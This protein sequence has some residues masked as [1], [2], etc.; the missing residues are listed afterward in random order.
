ML[1]SAPGTD[2]LNMW[3]G[4][5]D[6]GSTLE[7]IANHIASSDAFQNAYPAF[8]TN[9]EFATA[10]LNSSL[11]AEV[12]AEI[13]AAAAVVV[14]G[15]LN[16]GTS[17]GELALLVVGVLF[18]I[19][20]QG[21]AHGLAADFGAAA[22]A[23]ANKVDVAEYYTL[24]Q[25]IS[26]PSSSAI[27]DVSS[28]ADSVT[29]AKTAIDNL[30]AAGQTGEIFL[31]TSAR[32][33]LV[34]TAGGD[35]FFA[36]PSDDGH[37]L[38]AYDSIGAGEGDDTLTVYG[39]R[40]D[41]IINTER[42]SNLE[43]LVVDTL[44]GINVDTSDWT[45]L[46]SIELARFS[47]DV[48]VVA[49]GA[50]VSVGKTASG[51]TSI[52]GA[53]GDLELTA[54]K[55]AVVTIGAAGE[56]TSVSVKGGASVDISKTGDGGQ[57]ETVTSVSLDGVQR[58]LGLDGKRGTAMTPER[59]PIYDADANNNDIADGLE[60]N[61]TI[62]E[63][64]LP[65]ATPDVV[66][67]ARVTTDDAKMAAM[68]TVYYDAEGNVVAS[69]AEGA[70][71]GKDGPSA[72]VL[73]K[74]IESISLSNSDAIVAVIN[75]SDDPEDI[76]V[77]VDKFGK[78]AKGA[79]TAKL[80]LAGDGAAENVSI[81]VAGDSDFYLG[82]DA[83]KTVS[84]SGDA[85]V[86]LKV[87]MFDTAVASGTLESVTITDG[88]SV[89]MDAAGM[90]K[91]ESI[92]A[93]AGTGNNKLTGIGA[94]VDSV[95]GGSGND[96][97]ALAAHNIGGTMVSLGAGDDTFSSGEANNKSRVD[98]GEGMDTLN[99]KSD[100]GFT[101]TPE[102]GKANS[103]T[104]YSGFEALDVGGS[105]EATYNISL[106]GVSSVRVGGV[107]TVGTVTLNNMGD[108]MGISVHG[109]G[110]GTTATIVHN[111][112]EREVG[113]VRYSGELD[114]SLA[115]NGG[116]KDT[117]ATTNGEAR[118][119]LTTNGEIEVLNI[120]SSASAGGAGSAAKDRPSAGHYE[121][122]LTLDGANAV[123]AIAVSGNAKLMVVAANAGFGA[124]ELVDAED[125]TAGVTVDASTATQAVEMHGGSGGD[126]FTGTGQDDSLRGNGGKD[127][128]NGGGGDDKLRGGAG[129]DTLDGGGNTNVFEYTSTSDSQLSYSATGA[130][131]GFDTIEN[132]AGG[133]NT[134]SLGRALF[135][136]FQGGIKAVDSINNTDADDPPGTPNGT[137]TANSLRA[138]IG[139][140]D[141]L[142][143]TTGTP[144]EN[145]FGGGATI[146]NS[147]AVVTS[148]VRSDTDDNDVI[149]NSDDANEMTWVFI[150]VDGDGDFDAAVDMVI[151]LEGTVTIELGDFTM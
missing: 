85:K 27:A 21:D 75:G 57:S 45:G 146:K 136:S 124:L 89:T 29:A 43:N 96:T 20:A 98:G 80:C 143:E 24:D 6:D 93:S 34:G 92:D 105:A 79:V 65:D 148:N 49:D 107:S 108:G 35:S 40:D 71:T 51:V 59:N 74:A 11:G 66:D 117:K 25:R 87:T 113:D 9:E 78:H 83:T 116:A 123:E 28:D 70:A 134:I 7:E 16:D 90:G 10:F 38:Q 133:T 12:S 22:S 67:D 58:N 150:D 41:L 114:V 69:D 60:E 50:S 129:A 63:F 97:V 61:A 106:L 56:T 99:L 18:D 72:H 140:G 76:S 126:T 112:P 62:D 19:A 104:I 151:A 32:D 37:T 82:S 139:D 103:A 120:D 138:Y 127:T 118:L 100:V 4:L 122:M 53:G 95:T 121:N 42:V 46:E 68:L 26:G 47:G 135:N 137:S 30:D 39:G 55:A 109:F 145:T 144:V 91:L 125:N 94:K 86:A 81:N 14:V 44:G 36:E 54:G 147:V 110:A 8:L 149:D 141:G 52:V 17:R 15:V 31:L 130:P 77:T 111:M 2:Q 132:W 142:F 64:L 3:V 119:T 23:F 131:Q 128:L 1:G 33:S 84:I 88:A 115:A 48:T 13:I 73:S 102:G 5:L 101:Y